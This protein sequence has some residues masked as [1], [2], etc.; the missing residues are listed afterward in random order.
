MEGGAAAAAKA[1]GM[2]AAKRA[3]EALALMEA[4]LRKKNQISKML[5]GESEGMEWPDDLAQTMRELMEALIPKAGKGDEE[6]GDSEEAGEGKST[7]RGGAGKAG[8]SESGYTM[9][10]KMAQVPVYGPARSRLGRSGG[11]DTGRGKGRGG[12]GE[13]GTEVQQDEIAGAKARPPGGESLAAEAVP[14][15][16]REAVRRYFLPTE[17]NEQTDAKE[18]P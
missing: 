9:R 7:G 12:Q 2:T 5:N 1:D 16:Y 14:E 17:T 3:D 6:D 11:T 18:H 4:M 15:A 13:G 10:G 8:R